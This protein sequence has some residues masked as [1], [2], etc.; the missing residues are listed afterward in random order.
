[1]NASPEKVRDTKFHE[2]EFFDPRDLVQVKYE[3]LRRVRVESASVTHVAEEYGFSRPTYYQ[4]RA[5]FDKAGIAGLVP[6]KRGPRGRHKLNAEV[7][8]H[9]VKFATCVVLVLSFVFGTVSPSP[10]N[11]LNVPPETETTESLVPAGIGLPFTSFNVKVYAQVFVPEPAETDPDNNDKSGRLP[12][13]TMT[14]LFRTSA[15]PHA[16]L[17]EPSI[18]FDPKGSADSLRHADAPLA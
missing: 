1:M 5:G 3:M 8:A 14:A 6:K 9:P 2:G 11:T 15:F 4:A 13:N 18:D 16:P 17:Q 12:D 10:L 7:L